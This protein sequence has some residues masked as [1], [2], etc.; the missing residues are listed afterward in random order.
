MRINVTTDFQKTQTDRLV[1]GTEVRPLHHLVPSAQEK[2]YEPA[3]KRRPF[4]YRTLNVSGGRR[5]HSLQ[6]TMFKEVKLIMKEKC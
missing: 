4:Q 3:V 5:V 1:L 2:L 6:Q